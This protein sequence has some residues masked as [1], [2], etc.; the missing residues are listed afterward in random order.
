MKHTFPKIK[1]LV[2]DV[3]GVLL[4]SYLIHYR[5]WKRL[6][7]EISVPYNE[8]INAQKTSGQPRIH[9][10]KNV[11][12]EISDAEAIIL[13]ERKQAFF[14]EEINS[15]KIES[16]DGAE[17]FLKYL[18]HLGYKI[19]AASSSKNAPKL[20]EITGLKKYLNTI[21]SG[22]DFSNPKPDPEIFIKASQSLEILP[23]ELIVFEDAKVGIE[24]AKNGGFITVA[25]L[26]SNDPGI[27][28]LADYEINNLG[29]YKKVID[30][31]NL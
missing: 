3:D 16:I 9:A 4:D 24:A 14:L 12:P 23:C 8:E 28:D 27:K 18:K 10:I 21:I 22:S 11:I 5:A 26:D 19:C 1:G 17:E 15:G 7:D 20:L 30:N 6:F 13:A 25:I 29:S 2:F 31:F